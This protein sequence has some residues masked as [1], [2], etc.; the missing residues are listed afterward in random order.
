MD[1][2]ASEEQKQNT[3]SRPI[4]ETVGE[5][6][7]KL[8]IAGFAFNT[9]ED[10]ELVKQDIHKIEYLEQKM[11]YHLPENMLAIYDKV[12]EGNVLKTP[13]GWNYLHKMQT[14]MLKAG[15]APER[16]S[17]IPV[18]HSFTAAQ[19]QP[20]E[21]STSVAT[22][23]IER[24]LKREKSETAKYRNRYRTAVTACIL[25]GGLVVVM[26]IIA[27][28]SDTPNILNYENTITNKYASWEQDLTDREKK[29]RDKEIEIELN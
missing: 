20:S 15:I 28:K 12:L 14:S 18:H 6:R 24:R 19:A 29:L 1:T 5:A 3:E 10:V 27:L 26:F 16:V 2:N 17:P 11:D 23:R 21:L 9:P 8:I 25:L 7:Q 22:Q 4:P 13:L